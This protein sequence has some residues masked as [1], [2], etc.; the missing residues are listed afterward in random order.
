LKSFTKAAHTLQ[1]SQASITS[2][3]QQLEDEIGFPLFDRLGKQIQV[4]MIGKELYLYV[5]ELLSVYSKIKQIS[6][7]DNTMK[8][9]LRIGASETMTVNK[10][11]S[12]ISKYKKYYPEV[13]FSLINDNCM[14]L[15][16]RLHSGEL[17]IAITLEPKVCDPQLTTEIWSEEPLVFVGERNHSVKSI[18][19]ADGECI[20]FSANNCALRQSFEGYLVENRINSSNYLEF[21]SM[22]AMKQCV[23]SGL[24]ISLMPYISVEVLLRDERMKV[25]ESSCEN[26]MFYAQISY[27]K[28]KWL[29]KAHKKFIEMVLGGC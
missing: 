14:S 21:T 2:H 6:S 7:D 26:L 12:V 20:I 25:I 1:Y 18:E 28:N 22:E 29:S 23:V 9:E 19:E 11:G 3:I 27:H 5:V 10:L 8:G 15:R 13:T 24:G 16:E 4:T 17:D